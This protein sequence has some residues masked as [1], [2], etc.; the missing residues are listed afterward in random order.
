MITEMIRK[1]LSP[2]PAVEFK[3]QPSRR[4]YMLNAEL[5][6]TIYDKGYA[7]AGCLDKETLGKLAELYSGTHQ[8]NVPGGGM[9]YSLYSG[10]IPYRKKVHQAI[11]EILQPLYDS[12]FKDY[13]S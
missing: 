6:E 8:F 13:R 1:Y 4:P 7:V 10:D 12:L 3:W 11:G 5:E 9:F 2:Q